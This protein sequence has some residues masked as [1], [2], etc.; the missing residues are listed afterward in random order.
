MLC[1][2]IGSDSKSCT[3]RAVLC[4]RCESSAGCEAH[5]VQ[6]TM[7]SAVWWGV[8]GWSVAEAT[9]GLVGRREAEL[10]GA[11]SHLDLPNMETEKGGSGWREK[12]S[13]HDGLIIKTLMI[14]LRP[15]TVSGRRDA[16]APS[17]A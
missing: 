14:P 4:V 16:R 12:D 5:G 2:V 10:A 1:E 3:E 17:S 13:R 8:M 15:E 9:E 11:S 7:R 6:R